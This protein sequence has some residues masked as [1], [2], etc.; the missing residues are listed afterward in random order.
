MSNFSVCYIQFIMV[1][2][3][4]ANLLVVQS[5]KNSLVQW[6]LI[7]CFPLL[8]NHTAFAS[9]KTINTRNHKP[10]TVLPPSSN[11]A[12]NTP[13]MLDEVPHYTWCFARHVSNN[14]SIFNYADGKRILRVIFFPI[15]M[16]H[17]TYQWS[18]YIFINVVTTNDALPV[19][20]PCTHFISTCA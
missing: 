16:K 5:G 19:E 14:V 15:T 10:F 1:H 2:T 18:P 6:D 20:T 13:T 17:F 4:A 3:L 8:L 7:E 9:M 12:V 11:T